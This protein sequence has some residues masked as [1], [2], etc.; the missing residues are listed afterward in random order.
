MGNAETCG[1]TDRGCLRPTCQLSTFSSRWGHALRGYGLISCTYGV[2]LRRNPACC[3][4]GISTLTQ[5]CP[6]NIQYLKEVP[7]P[8]VVYTA[9]ER[10]RSYFCRFADATDSDRIANR[11]PY[12]GTCQ[13]PSTK[14]YLRASTDMVMYM[15]K[16]AVGW[17]FN[18][19]FS[20]GLESH[21]W[22]PWGGGS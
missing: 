1:Y 2:G 21:A 10:D 6:R 19:F 15:T 5:A 9:G 8:R 3:R 14:S 22:I 12:Y 16:D 17:L 7:S 13:A 4:A 11:K 20:S 18:R